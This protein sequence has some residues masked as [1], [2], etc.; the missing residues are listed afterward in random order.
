LLPV[1]LHYSHYEHFCTK[2]LII[3]GKPFTI[4]EFFEIY[5]TE[6]NNA[7]LALNAK[8]RAVLKDMVIDIEDAEHYQEYDLLRTFIAKKR[9]NQQKRKYSFYDQF[10]AERKVVQDIDE[11]KKEKPVQFD[12]LMDYTKNYLEG[13]KKMNLRDY[14]IGKKISLFSLF[15]KKLLLILVAPFYL[16]AFANNAIPYLIPEILIRKTKDRQF[17]SSVRYLVSFI[18]FPI[19]YLI[20]LSVIWIIS[21][22]FLFTAGYLVTAAFMLKLVY[23]YKVALIKYWHSLRYRLMRKKP[24][25]QKLLNLKENILAIFCEI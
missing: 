12:E 21:G 8:A 1:C 16:F 3:I 17:H 10:Q 2:L 19:Y 24:S 14:L 18:V 13:L 22:S 7:Y 11:L 9:L 6:P 20:L 5:K 25:I 23:F 15:I 4:D